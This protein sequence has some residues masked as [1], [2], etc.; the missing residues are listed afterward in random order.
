[1]NMK[2]KRKR[3]LI[4]ALFIWLVGSACSCGL[5]PQ[6]AFAFAN[7]KMPKKVV[8]CSGCDKPIEGS[9]KYAPGETYKIG[10]I[11][12]ID[13]VYLTVLGWDAPNIVDV[14]IFNRTA[15]D[16]P[17][18][19]LSQMHLRDANGDTFTSTPFTSVT[20][21]IDF[22][23]NLAPGDFVHG[24]VGFITNLNM[25]AR[26]M[27]FVF[28][29]D[30]SNKTEVLVSLGDTPT[31]MPL[32]TV[33]VEAVTGAAANPGETFQVG[34]IQYTVTNIRWPRGASLAKPMPGAMFVL[35]DVKVKN[36]GSITQIVSPIA[37]MRV[38]DEALAKYQLSLTVL[39][40]EKDAYLP[41]SDHLKPGESITGQVGFEV[42]A[43]ASRLA[44]FTKDYYDGGLRSYM[45]IPLP[46]KIEPTPTPA[47]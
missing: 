41:Q 36:V 25:S 24:Q 23:K 34:D 21:S 45:A 11:V 47:P 19:T 37:Q 5:L 13:G 35:M 17:V 14:A 3:I 32:Q 33:L 12:N 18:Y 42:P 10:D 29:I 38:V 20:L 6:A 43:K 27:A 46:V 26:G 31:R 44:M 8:S 16:I 15:K 4:V 2:I 40:A 30:G 7:A 22:D 9:L 28:D 1:M 39:G